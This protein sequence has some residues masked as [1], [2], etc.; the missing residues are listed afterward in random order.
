MS[1][2][3]HHGETVDAKPVILAIVATETVI[4]NAVTVVAAAFLP[5]AVLGSPV[6]CAITL[7]SDLLFAGLSGAPLLSCRVVLLWTLPAL[8]ILLPSGLLSLVRGVVPLLTLLSSLILLTPVFLL[9]LL[10][11]L[12]LLPIGLRLVLFCRL[13]P[14]LLLLVLRF[15]LLILT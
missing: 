7:P 5:V 11:P 14:L 1:A 15:I 13:L 8:L 6:M 3:I 2:N 9:W 10:V 4:R 12:I